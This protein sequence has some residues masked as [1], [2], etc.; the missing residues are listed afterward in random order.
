[1]GSLEFTVTG[2]LREFDVTA[3]LPSLDLPVLFTCGEFDEARP[4]TVRRHAAPVPGARVVEL[5]GA[6]HLPLLESP[7]PYWSAVRTFL[8]DVEEGSWS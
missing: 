4:G 2:T 7:E 3:D 6:S 1:M 5:P 8:L